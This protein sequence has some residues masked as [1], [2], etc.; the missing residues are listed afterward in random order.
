MLDRGFLL[1]PTPG[2]ETCEASMP[3]MWLDFEISSVLGIPCKSKGDFNNFDL[4]GCRIFST[5]LVRSSFWFWI[6]GSV[7]FLLNLGVRSF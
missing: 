1:G 6:S 5:I 3:S 2:T 7:Y 4:P